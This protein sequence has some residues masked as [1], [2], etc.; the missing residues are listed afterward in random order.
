MKTSS[1]YNTAMLLS[2]EL[3]RKRD[4]PFASGHNEHIIIIGSYLEP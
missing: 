3:C 1:N 2:A 4:I